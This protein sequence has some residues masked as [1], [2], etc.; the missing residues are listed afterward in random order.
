[1]AEAQDFTRISTKSY[2]VWRIL[3]AP[4]VWGQIYR[5]REERLRNYR[6]AIIF[7]EQLIG[8]NQSQVFMMSVDQIG[9]DRRTVTVSGISKTNLY[10][11]NGLVSEY[12]QI[13]D[14]ESQH[15]NNDALTGMTLNSPSNSTYQSVQFHTLNLFTNKKDAIKMAQGVISRF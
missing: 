14:W 6:S 2:K 15:H 10:L 9:T 1:M 4:G 8:L 11:D 13:Y 5:D 3:Q 7:P 12:Q